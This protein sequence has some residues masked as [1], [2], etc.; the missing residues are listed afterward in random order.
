[1]GMQKAVA[2]V[3]GGAMI[4]LNGFVGLPVD[5]AVE[6]INAIVSVGTAVGVFLVQNRTQ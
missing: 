4:M 5:L 6:W 2:A 3:I 1:M